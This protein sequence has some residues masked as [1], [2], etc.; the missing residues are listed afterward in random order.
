MVSVCGSRFSHLKV[1]MECGE[2]AVKGLIMPHLSA[3]C[4]EVDLVRLVFNI[5][6]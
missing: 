2:V 6:L 3:F 5:T 4:V 1:N